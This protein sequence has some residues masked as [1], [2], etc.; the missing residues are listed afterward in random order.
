MIQARA[1]GARRPRRAAAGP[2]G[3]ASSGRF[4]HQKRAQTQA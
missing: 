2:A 1:S 3:A 4:D